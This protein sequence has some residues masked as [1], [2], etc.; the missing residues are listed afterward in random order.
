MRHNQLA[1]YP[2]EDGKT[3]FD[4]ILEKIITHRSGNNNHAKKRHFKAITCFVSK[5]SIEAFCNKAKESGVTSIEILVDKQS[6]EKIKEI[7]LPGVT[8]YPVVKDK[9]FHG[10]AYSYQAG[11]SGKNGFVIST[12]ANFSDAFVGS[13]Y[14]LAYISNTKTALSS[15]N[16]IFDE[17]KSTAA[18]YSSDR[19]D[20][21]SE[22]IATGYLLYRC[23]NT[24][25]STSKIRLRLKEGINTQTI[26]SDILK[27]LGAEIEPKTVSISPFGLG[28]V[29]IPN[30]Q[31]ADPVTTIKIYSE[32]TR[33]GRWMPRAIKKEIFT[34]YSDS[35]KN[36]TS[37]I[38]EIF[39]STRID[40][41][42]SEMKRRISL[43]EVK[44]IL[45]SEDEPKIES[46]FEDFRESLSSCNDD[47]LIRD[48]FFGYNQ[49]EFS[50]FDRDGEPSKDFIRQLNGEYLTEGRD[51]ISVGRIS[52]WIM[53]NNDGIKDKWNE[54]LKE[55]AVEISKQANACNLHIDAW[56][57][58]R[59][60]G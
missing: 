54:W 46:L 50:I 53:A 33:Y 27:I 40:T 9:L 52:S 5:G 10:K 11:D 19:W 14:E 21:A 7:S 31:K 12:S 17:L 29:E 6:Y 38:H 58:E 59:N 35:L 48:T 56:K 37:L 39:S 36:Y 25:F 23:A 22:Y 60:N 55:S 8:I 24:I 47:E 26:E 18:N 44:G 49:I 13:S 32:S 43:P 42:I 20:S 16:Y 1:Q 51:K 3:L 45:C 30:L 15:F 4:D 28:L 2:N 57:K 41:I 34:R